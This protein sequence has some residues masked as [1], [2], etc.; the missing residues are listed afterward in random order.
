MQLTG[1]LCA[2]IIY[3]LE[4]AGGFFYPRHVQCKKNPTKAYLHARLSLNKAG[5]LTHCVNQKY[6]VDQL[7]AEGVKDVTAAFFALLSHHPSLT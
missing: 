7:D 3:S 6:V 5:Q 4:L 1:P 2:P